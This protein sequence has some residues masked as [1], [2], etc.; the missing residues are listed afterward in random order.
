[1]NRI[2]IFSTAYLPFV[3]GAEL[4]IKEITDRLSPSEFSFDLITLN[5]DRKQKSEEKVGNIRVIRLSCSKLL[6]PFQ[7]FVRARKIHKL[8]P[9]DRVWSVM[10]S[11]GGFAG[12]FFKRHFPKISFILTLQ[13]GDSFSHIYRRVF[14]V[15]P[16]FKKIFTRADKITA[17]SNYLAD[18]ARRMGATAPIHVVPNG[19]DIEKFKNKNEKGKSEEIRKEL[20]I[21][22]EDKIVITTSRL[23]PKNG[24]GDLIEA[25]KHLPENMKLLILGTGYLEG[26]LKLQTTNYKLQTR[27]KFLG[28]IPNSELPQ[29]LHASDIF[30][31][32]ALSEG[33]GISFLEAMAAGLPVIATP[34][35]GIPDFLASPPFQGGDT[36]GGSEITGL[37]CEVNNPKSIADKVRLLLSNDE[38]RKRIIANASKMV[39]EKYDWDI[40]AQAM[41][42][43]IF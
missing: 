17:I 40:L 21:K 9:Y 19:V 39:R 11:Y 2:L 3:G 32:P 37:F 7:A 12:L 35:G 13:E 4:A 16:L 28:F 43:K 33:L 38:L 5:L 14:F 24:V 23:V 29:Y 31:R 1:M 20:R 25:M 41:S 18:W 10:A 8:N 42:K 36:R 6:F 26:S 15:W 30:C 22:P 34:V 27:V